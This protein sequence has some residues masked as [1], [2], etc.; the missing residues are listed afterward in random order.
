MTRQADVRDVQRADPRP[1][2]GDQVLIGAKGPRAA[3]PGGG[4][5]LEALFEEQC[6][7]LRAAGR[8]DRRAVDAGDVVLTYDELDARANRLARYLLKQ[9]ARPGDRIA[10]LFDHAVH[11]YAGML[12]VL[13]IN[14]AYVPMDAGFPADRLAYIVQDAGVRMVLSLSHLRGRVEHVDAGILYVDEAES[15]VAAE[16]DRRLT[17][18]ERGKPVDELCYII[19]TSGST[20]RPKGVAIEHAGI[21]NF[22]RVAVEAYEMRADDRVYQ[23]MTIAFDFSV[24]EIWVPLLSGATLV[25]RPPGV[26]LLGHELWEFLRAC[27]VTALCCVPTLLATL[28]Q[29]LPGLRFLL[30]SGEACPADLVRRWHRPGR[31]LLNVYGPTEA[32]VTATCKVLHPSEPVTLGVPLPTYSVVILDPAG[33]RVLPP[34]E[35]GEIGIAGIGLA[36]GYVNRDDLTEKAFIPDFLGL[37]DNPSGRIYRTGDLGRVNDDGEI[38][39]HGRID[40]QVQIHGYRI[41][42]AE[43]ESV[44]LQVPG[45][46]QAVV[47]TYEPEPG[48]VELV[49]YYSPREDTPHLGQEDIYRQLRG[50]LPGYMVPAYVEQLPDI[51][52]LLSNKADRKNL[53]PPKGPRCLS[54][55]HAYVAPS[56]PAET[57]LAGTLAEVACLEQV[58]VDSHFFDE[59]G[60]NSLL[61][62]RFCARV[63][64]RADLAPV[65]MK[66]VYLHPTV[67]SLATALADAAPAVEPRPPESRPAPSTA[68]YLLCGALQLLLFL[69]YAYLA[70]SVLV[71]AYGWISGATGPVDIYLR[72]LVSGGAI[73]A[74]LCA[75]P[76][77]AKWALVGR[78]KPGEIP[79][80]SLSYLRFW[81]VKTLVR[82]SPMVLF[83][84]SPLYVLYLRALGARIGPGVVILS[85][86]VPVCTDLLS[87]GGGTVIRKDSYFPCYRARAGVVETGPVT[88]GQDAYVGEATVIDIGATLGDGAQL[89]HSSSLQSS[90]SVPDGRR[91]HGSPAQPTT[92]DYRTV[93][94]APCGTW[95]RARFGA[96]Q[97]L[98]ALLVFIPLTVGGTYLL[99][100]QVPSLAVLTGTPR[101]AEPAGPQLYWDALVTSGVLFFGAILAGLALAATVPRLLNRALEPDEAYPLYGFRYGALRAITRITNLPF[102]MYLFGDSSYVVHYLRGLGYG[103][104][105][106]EQTGSNFGLELKHETPYL[107]SVGSGTMVSDGLSIMNADF[108][109]T[110]FRVSRAT[111]GA[112]TFVGNNIAYPS[113]SRAGDNC[114]LAT[115]VMIPI[116]GEPRQDVGL[117]GSPCFEIPRS[118]QRDSGFDHLKTGEEFRRRLSAKNG[119]NR[120]TMALYLLVRWVYVF[121]VTLL[122]LLALSLYDRLGTPVIAADLVLTLVFTAGYFVLAERVAIGFRRLEPRFC[123]IYQPYYWWHE[124]YWKLSVTTHL[125]VLNGTPFKNL[126]WRLLGVRLGRRVFDDGGYMPEKTLVTVGSDCTLAEGSLIQAHSLEDG[127]F[128]SDHIV[129]GEGCSV[130]TRALVHY[131]V[132]MGDGAVLDADSFLMKGEE[133]APH[134][135]WRGN[136]A[137]QI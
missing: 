92:T 102:F 71:G 9:G 87:I 90:Q 48:V 60:A 137:K 10:L 65:S 45:V 64:E 56:T 91:W 72:S 12:A 3:W 35:L 49:A 96:A 13:K 33:A 44:L 123:S 81:T 84:G 39:Y 66:D 38:E 111:V 135:H 75:F 61:M 127:T 47:D 106:V 133:L 105:T 16:D 104:S 85:K 132:R 67:R 26:T 23:G 6:D 57:V 98:G 34:G 88:I 8:G 120:V 99:G 21:C 134:A 136:P 79:V 29:D 18:D 24:E 40:T 129:I 94:P 15:L 50:R 74:A 22:V 125:D 93:E 37:P 100:T 11:S 73:F 58:S 128:K 30:V 126:F 20:G 112:R 28:D 27:R 19:Y 62:A 80:W 110:S 43:I 116:D 78:W 107:T 118:V 76:V 25:P 122:S 113:Q 7:R 54:T 69:G 109:S 114:L 77:V 63:R 53:P 115:K 55:R 59:L 14:A 108:S 5:R 2:P 70:A 119:H 89:G 97:L 103:L 32:T 31:R 86:N 131:G 52:M 82:R 121:G 42:L 46:A 68:R 17:D 83:T 95:R 124:R 51:P 101:A 1:A 130:G 4:K 36:G 117:L 41:E